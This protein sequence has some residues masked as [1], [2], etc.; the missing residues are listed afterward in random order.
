MEWLIAIV[1]LIVAWQGF[2]RV[3][4]GKSFSP[5]QVYQ[6]A[7]KWRNI[8]VEAEQASPEISEGL[9]QWVKK[10]GNMTK[11]N[12]VLGI[13]YGY[14]LASYKGDARDF[15]DF[16]KEVDYKAHDYG[17][18]MRTG[19]YSY[20]YQLRLR[21]KMDEDFWAGIKLGQKQAGEGKN[22]LLEERQTW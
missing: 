9:F 22:Y 21:K 1:I 17:F 18:L 3:F 11:Y 10:P 15:D 16:L 13:M 19:K 20:K 12:K 6:V 14:I 7:M 5:D 2:R 8:E 4:V